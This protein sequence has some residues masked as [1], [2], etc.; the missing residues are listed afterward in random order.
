M[1]IKNA[2]NHKL[3]STEIV[4]QLMISMLDLMSLKNLKNI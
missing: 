4:K 1:V 3:S 2:R